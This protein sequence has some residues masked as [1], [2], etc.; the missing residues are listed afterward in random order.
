MNSSIEGTVR[1]LEQQET[2]KIRRLR[3]AGCGEQWFEA[4]E[5]L[6]RHQLSCLP[7]K[8]EKAELEK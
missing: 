5:Q 6:Y 4:G 7:M 1:S 2:G 3:C 8:A